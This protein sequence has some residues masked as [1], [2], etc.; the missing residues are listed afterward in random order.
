ML[1]K[2]FMLLFFFLTFLVNVEAKN[3]KITKEPILLTEKGKNLQTRYEEELHELKMSLEKVL[4]NIAPSLRESYFKA[5]LSQTQAEKNLVVA[6][7]EAPTALPNYD[8]ER[9]RIA[10][11]RKRQTFKMYE[12]LKSAAEIEDNRG[13]L[14]GAN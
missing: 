13:S 9:K 10:D 3:K 1:I 7:K 6:K 4:P 2:H 14:Y 5:R 8:S 12:A 11:A